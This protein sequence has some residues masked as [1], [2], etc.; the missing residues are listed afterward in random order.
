MTG[1]QLAA[2]IRRKTKTDSTTYTDANIL[3]D[4]NLMK[5]EIAAKIAA[6][7]EEAF[8]VTTNDDLADDQRLYPYETDVM[9]QLVRL[10]L[11]FT[12]SGDY[13]LATPIQLRQV[14]IPMQ[15]SLI[16]GEYGNESPFYFIRGKHIYILSGTIVDVTDGIQWVYR[17]FPVDLANITGV[18]DLSIDTSATELGFPREFHELWARRVSIEYKNTNNVPLSKK[19]LDYEIDLQK[20]IDDFDFPNA[21]QEIIGELPSGAYRGYDGYDY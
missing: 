16:V 19:E 7:K 12:A 21:D 4:I 10:E 13:V 2:L 20:A 9:N 17:C 15:E 1:A 3:I 11:K 14:R 6:A 8:N 18:T 5:D